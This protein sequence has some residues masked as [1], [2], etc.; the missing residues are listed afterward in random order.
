MIGA[1]IQT[2]T[3]LSVYRLTQLTRLMKVEC[4][5]VGDFQINVIVL[6]T[7]H[8]IKRLLYVCDSAFA[9]VLSSPSDY[10]K[11]VELSSFGPAKSVEMAQWVCSPP[12]R[13]TSG[14]TLTLCEIVLAKL[15]ADKQHCHCTFATSRS[16]GSLTRNV[17]I[18]L[19][20][21]CLL[22]SFKPSRE[23]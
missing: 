1:D 6:C 9:F 19:I 12:T 20:E 11:I 4:S 7:Q 10:E 16:M 8:H 22:L 15:L 5:V 2:K 18:V 21:E 14:S 13:E 23:C 3:S 17:G